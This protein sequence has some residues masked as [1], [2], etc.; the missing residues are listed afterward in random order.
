MKAA[1]PLDMP[2]AE[3]FPHGTRSCYVC[4]CR[5]P[6]C[7]AAN[8]ARYRERMRKMQELAV[9]VVPTGPPRRGTMRRAGRTYRV[10]RCPGANGKP[11]V[12]RRPAW[13]RGQGAVCSACLERATV[14]DGLVPPDKARKH[15]LRLRAAGVGY[16]AV[17]AASDLATSL[18][19]QILSGGDRIRASTERRVLA[20]DEAA[21]ADHA[22]VDARA[23]NATI[24]E[25]R[26]RG[27]TLRQLGEL[28][29]YKENSVLQL[30]A[31]DRATAIT[32]KK[33]ER[34]LRRVELGEVEPARAIC[35]AAE[36]RAWLEH[37]LG[38]GVPA[39]WLSLRLGFVV[40]PGG[41][42]RMFAKNRDAVRELRAEV[43][44]LI[45]EGDGLPEDWKWPQSASLRFS[46]GFG[47]NG[48]WLIR[49]RAKLPKER[50]SR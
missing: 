49:G 16:R 29:G 17:A 15:L 23:M 11:C 19:S 28:L 2:P 4:G 40:A 46:Q 30:G 47:F 1:R 42:G 34:L 25:L 43:V 22:L 21:V 27:F 8:A 6:E 12:R 41:S 3:R 44:K 9:D 7:R 38:R 5:C 45:R 37:L 36:E 14:W 26:G 24:A 31:R 35:G 32:V 20:V 10:K 13:L 39:R 48:G 18:V 50:D 33:V